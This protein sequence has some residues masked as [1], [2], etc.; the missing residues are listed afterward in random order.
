MAEFSYDKLMNWPFEEIA[1]TYGE[2][3]TILY[4][5]SIGIGYDPLDEKQLNYVFEEADFT[6]APTMAVVLASP[7]F[8]ARHPET[9][10]EWEKI[11]HGEQEIVL[12][13]PLP[14]AATVKATTKIS[15]ILDKG[16]GKNALIYTT[17]TL[18]D[19]ATGDELATLRSTLI[20]RGHGGFGGKDGPQPQPHPTPQREPNKICDLPTAPNSALIYRLDGDTNP[21]HVSPKVAAEAGFKAPILHGLCSFGIA[22]HALLRTYCD[23]D[24]TRLKS[25]KLRFASPVYPGETI[26]TEMWQ[27][28]NV[29]S[30]RSK[31]IER[32]QIVLSNGR[33]EISGL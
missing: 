12:H 26:R 22:G 16:E 15:E 23:Y 13:T 8:W 21:L 19:D 7:G 4:A 24:A 30:L 10:I 17:R 6:S 33:A 11:L 18:V 1:H 3:D 32:D 5:L 29:I 25:L 31:V 9:G 27:D 28:G 14:T 20:A 2:R